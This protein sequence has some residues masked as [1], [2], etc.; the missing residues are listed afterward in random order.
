MTEQELLEQET[1]RAQQS[2]ALR[3]SVAQAN[4]FNTL[5]AVAQMANNPGAAKASALI[6]SLQQ[7]RYKPVS[8]GQAGF[9][10]PESGEF[11]ESPMYVDEKN[12]ARA[13]AKEARELAD[14]TK[15]DLEEARRIE[16]EGRAE[17]DRALRKSLADQGAA[18]RQQGLDIQRELGMGR[19]AL[20]DRTV[21]AKE[22][23][24]ANGKLLPAGETAKLAKR[25]TIASAFGDLVEGFKPEFGGS[26]GL[27]KAENLLGKF[28]P[29]G[30]GKKY[31]PQSNWWQAYNEQSNIIRNEMFGSALTALEK[32]A[33]EKATITEGME[34]KQMET[35]LKQQHA[36][37]VSAYNKLKRA[38]NKVGYST[39]EL[40]E[41][42]MPSATLPGMDTRPAPAAPAVKGVPAGVKPEVWNLMTPEQKALFK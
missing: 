24:P 40:E 32:A 19:L 33:Y 20:G 13:A 36:A 4:K 23:K 34:P 17:A 6:Q 31:G 11:I 30:V 7:A 39:G 8:L 14:R 25:M 27:A 12:A 10:L 15:R 18:L 9:A 38:Y 5:A 1:R 21:T 26:P 29:L 28:Q 42:T 35:K 22:N 2:G 16:R 3:Q 41:L 37:V